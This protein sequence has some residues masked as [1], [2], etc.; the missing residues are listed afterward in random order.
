MK[1]LISGF[2]LLL[3][4]LVP[5]MAAAQTG[6]LDSPECPTA[7]LAVVGASAAMLYSRLRSR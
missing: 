3:V 7:V 6:C 2:F 5:V 4:L 1:V